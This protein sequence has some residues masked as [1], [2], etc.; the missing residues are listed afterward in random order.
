MP[1]KCKIVFIIFFAFDRCILWINAC[2]QE[3]LR[4]LSP[5]ELHNK[6]RICQDHFDDCSF[7]NFLKNRLHDDAC[8]RTFCF[9]D[10]SIVGEDQNNLNM[11][12]NQASFSNE[13]KNMPNLI[14]SLFSTLKSKHK[15]LF[16]HRITR[17]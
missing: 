3:H 1:V 8:P 9:E 16:I 6:C 2:G 11:S 4:N 15:L 17:D 13:G 12:S 5:E 7:L 10:V 14:N